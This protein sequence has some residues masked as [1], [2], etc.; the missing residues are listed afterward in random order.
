MLFGI[1]EDTLNASNLNITNVKNKTSRQ[2]EVKWKVYANT[3]CIVYFAFIYNNLINQ[4]I[5]I[6]SVLRN[7]FWTNLK[8]SV[9][10]ISQEFNWCSIE[11]FKIEQLT[12]YYIIT[13]IS[14][15][16]LNS[17]WSKLHNCLVKNILWKCTANL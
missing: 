15:N 9:K 10:N 4:S 12:R 5:N 17:V 7:W 16:Q 13:W 8:W 1:A 14:Y 3:Q 11:I 2:S 6:F